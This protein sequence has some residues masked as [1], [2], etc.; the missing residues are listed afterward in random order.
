MKFW[1]DNGIDGFRIDA[2]PHLY[3]AA[4][5]SLNETPFGENLNLSLHASFNHTL[6]KD[7]PETYE[8]VSEWRKFV[9]TYAKDNN[10]DEI[11]R[12]KKYIFANNLS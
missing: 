12:E 7:Q 8:I 2:I 1:L 9:D 4:N 3:E 5:I 6:T 11:V 10:R